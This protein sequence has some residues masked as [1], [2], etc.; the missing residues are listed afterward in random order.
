MLTRA[1]GAAAGELLGPQEHEIPAPADGAGVAAGAVP[2]E[3]D[4]DGAGVRAG[5]A[6]GS[7]RRAPWASGRGS[8]CSAFDELPKMPPTLLAMSCSLIT[9][10]EFA[11]KDSADISLDMDFIRS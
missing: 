9:L 1:Q 2:E 4:A 10:K 8:R 3:G 5:S 6:P 7:A 11:F